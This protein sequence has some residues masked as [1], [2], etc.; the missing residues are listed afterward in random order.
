MGDDAE[1]YFE[2]MMED[3]EFRQLQR[4]LEQ[5]REDK[6]KFKRLVKKHRKSVLFLS[7]KIPGP[8]N[9][10]PNQ[11]CEQLGI[12]K[13]VYYECLKTKDEKDNC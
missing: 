13:S 5:K 12:H 2:T 11:I 8:H 1:Y 7:K 3:P 9:L 10:T 6:E 4:E